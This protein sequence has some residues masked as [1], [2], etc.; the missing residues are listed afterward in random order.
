[1]ILSRVLE[2]AV[3]IIFSYGDILDLNFGD[4]AICVNR[5]F[6]NNLIQPNMLKAYY[7]RSKFKLNHVYI[8]Y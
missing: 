8:L 2:H 4:L 7:L 1:M 5:N 6:L 3:E